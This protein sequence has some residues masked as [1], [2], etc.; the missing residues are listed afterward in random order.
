MFLTVAPDGTAPPCHTA[1]MLPGSSFPNV[2]ER[3]LREIWFDS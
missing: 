3:G 2:K 1:K